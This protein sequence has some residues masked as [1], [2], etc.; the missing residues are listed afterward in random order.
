MT[1]VVTTIYF[2]DQAY[3]WIRC[4]EEICQVIRM[5][6]TYIVYANSFDF[7]KVTGHGQQCG[8]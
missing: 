8:R 3:Q 4:T 2:H 5:V 1:T 7:V 6:R